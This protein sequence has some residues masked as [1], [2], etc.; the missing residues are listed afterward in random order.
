MTEVINLVTFCSLTSAVSL[1]QLELASL[2][3]STPSFFLYVVKKIKQ[4]GA[5]TGNEAIGS[6]APKTGSLHMSV[7][8][9]HSNVGRREPSLVPRPHPLPRTG[10]EAKGSLDLKPICMNPLTRPGGGGGGGG[11]LEGSCTFVGFSVV[12][13][14]KVF[15]PRSFMSGAV[16]QW[17]VLLVYSKILWCL[18]WLVL[19]DANL[20]S[21][22]TTATANESITVAV[23][24][25]VA[26]FPG[27]AG[28]KRR[29]LQNVSE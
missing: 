9:L 18:C 12:V 1:E 2:P 27:P 28:P 25:T 4:L 14:C 13:N 6:L 8:G 20:A 3:V 22:Q 19:M 5:E 11:V 21:P 26:S 29:L 7:P 16:G 15:F 23:Y 17:N 10:N 24:T